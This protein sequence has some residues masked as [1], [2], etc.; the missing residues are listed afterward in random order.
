MLAGIATYLQEKLLPFLRPL[1]YKNIT[2]TTC[3][4]SAAKK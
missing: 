4:T 1:K 3:D 2:Y